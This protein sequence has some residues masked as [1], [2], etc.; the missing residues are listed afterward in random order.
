MRATNEPLPASYENNTG[1]SAGGARHALGDRCD[2][3]GASAAEGDGLAEPRTAIP[4]ARLDVVIPGE[5]CAAT[6]V[7]HDRDALPSR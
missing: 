5:W 1:A 4:T 7:G 2:R 6:Q 3:A